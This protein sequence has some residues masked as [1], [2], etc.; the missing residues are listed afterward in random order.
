[1]MEVYRLLRETHAHELSASGVANRWNREGEWVIYAGSSRSLSTLELLVH[2]HTMHLPDAYCMMVIGIQIN[3]GII[4]S[5]E[6]SDLPK[7]WKQMEAIPFLQS[8]GSKWYSSKQSA[9]LRVPSVIIEKEYNYLINTQHHDFQ[10]KVSIME[11]ESYFWDER[12]IR[13]REA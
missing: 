5:I 11:R 6:P 12:L 2:R 3:T 13:K 4:P 1:M 8:L 9:L 7:N 10:K